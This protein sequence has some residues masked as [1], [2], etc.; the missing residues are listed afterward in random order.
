MHDSAPS[1]LRNLATR[2]DAMTGV[3]GVALAQWAIRD[4]T[5]AQPEI[6]QAANTAVAA[7]DDMLAAL[8]RARQQL[9][10]EVRAADDANAARVDA[11]LAE[12][13]QQREAG[14]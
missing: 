3:L 9:V 5:K 6:R 2:L 14:K 13:R 8:H 1:T 10:T 4:E 7:I 12:T 11:M